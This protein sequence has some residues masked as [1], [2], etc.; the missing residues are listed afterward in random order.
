MP[1]QFSDKVSSNARVVVKTVAAGS[2][3]LPTIALEKPSRGASFGRGALNLLSHVFCWIPGAKY[4]KNWHNPAQWRA[5]RDAV[6]ATHAGDLQESRLT[7]DQLDTI[8]STY[9]SNRRLTQAKASAVLEDVRR[10]VDG[11]RP[12]PRFE[13]RLNSSQ[14][15]LVRGLRTLYVNCKGLGTTGQ[16]LLASAR[17]RQ[18]PQSVAM[19]D[20]LRPGK[21]ISNKSITAG[22]EALE[23]YAAGKANFAWANG[24][25][26]DS[27]SLKLNGSPPY[28]PGLIDQNK[29]AI[30]RLRAAAQNEPGKP[31]IL[32]IPLR[33]DAKAFS[34]HEAHAVELAVDFRAKKLLF[35]DAKGESIDEAGKNYGSGDV[36][37]ALEKFG[38]GMFGEPWSPA[39]GIVQ[40]TQAKQQ[41]ANDCGAF[42]HDFTR[43]LIDGDSV[44]DIERSFTKLDR[45]ELRIKMARDIELSRPSSEMNVPVETGRLSNPSASDDDF[46][47]VQRGNT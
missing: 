25:A 43:R 31:A 38:K 12:K 23:K 13:G 20:V 21:M 45:W 24:L 22:Q 35:L 7:R 29:D 44:G 33:F 4:T 32:S 5:F 16:N 34:L 46:F 36:R 11:H 26:A 28:A 15:P 17:L 40:L 37:G 47:E 9:S 18:D 10:V 30:S 41:G 8:F 19:A 2:D 14:A 6:L 39:E 42:T 3:G 27:L 1:I